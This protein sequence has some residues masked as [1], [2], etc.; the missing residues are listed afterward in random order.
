MKTSINFDKKINQIKNDNK[1]TERNKELILKFYD[2]CISLGLSPK[3]KYKYL[4]ILPTIAEWL[5]KDFDFL[6]LEDVKSLVA[7]IESTGYAD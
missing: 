5:S 2:D 3:R 7:K 1:I 6:G 4:C